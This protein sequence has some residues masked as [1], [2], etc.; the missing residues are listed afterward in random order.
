MKGDEGSINRVFNSS[1]QAPFV[2]LA[3]GQFTEQR[4]RGQ[5]MVF[6]SGQMTNQGNWDSEHGLYA[7]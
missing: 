1:F 2:K 3:D 7:G 5:P 4:Y 6:P